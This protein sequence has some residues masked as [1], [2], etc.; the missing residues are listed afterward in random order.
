MGTRNRYDAVCAVSDK[1]DPATNMSIAPREHRELSSIEHA[2]KFAW[3]L[4]QR[5]NL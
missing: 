3:A 5:D 1:M 4:Y 2:K